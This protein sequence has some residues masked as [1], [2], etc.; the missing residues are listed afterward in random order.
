MPNGCW[1]SSDSQPT[2]WTKLTSKCHRIALICHSNK[3]L[4]ISVE[5]LFP[6]IIW[7]CGTQLFF[8]KTFDKIHVTLSSVFNIFVS[9]IIHNK[10][11]QH[12]G[13]SNHQCERGPYFKRGRKRQF[14]QAMN[15]PYILYTLRNGKTKWLVIRKEPERSKASESNSH[16]SA[17]ENQKDKSPIKDIAVW[18][19]SALFHI[20]LLV[21]SLNM[22]CVLNLKLSTVH[23]SV[24]SSKYHSVVFTTMK[25]IIL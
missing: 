4:H 14:P 20:V 9:F 24:F 15:L 21:S 13:V 25:F 5:A 16:Y 7:N 3:T 2:D 6:R 18:L 10:V 22:T 12:G 11:F 23:S 8:N 17:T 19:S 1:R